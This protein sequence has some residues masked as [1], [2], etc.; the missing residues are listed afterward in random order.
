MDES[1]QKHILEAQHSSFK[2][3]QSALM[4][5]S[6]DQVGFLMFRKSGIVKAHANERKSQ[7]IL[8]S[9]VGLSQ[10]YEEDDLNQ[11]EKNEA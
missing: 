2:R 4:K 9:K 5:S 8:S 7:S 3:K 1:N 11:Y 10:K 6:G